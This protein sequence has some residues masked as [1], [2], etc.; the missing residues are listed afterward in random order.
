MKRGI[1]LAL[2]CAAG[3]AAQ[4]QYAGLVISEIITN[5]TDDEMIEVTNT[6]ASNIDISGVIVSDEETAR[7]EGACSFPASTTLAAGAT[8]VIAVGASTVEPT[9]LDTVPA[10]VQVFTEPGRVS[11]GWTPAHGNTITAMVDFTGATGTTGG[12][13][14]SGTDNAILLQPSATFSS[15]GIVD[16][17]LTIDG[18]SWDGDGPYCPINSTGQIDTAITEMSGDHRS[19]LS[20]QRSNSNPSIGS[21]QTYVQDSSNVGTFPESNTAKIRNA[22][23]YQRTVGEGAVAKTLRFDSLFSSRQLINF[24]DYDDAMAGSD[25]EFRY[26]TSPTRKTVPA[27][28]AE[29]PTATVGIN[30]N[31]FDINGTGETV[32]Y[33]KVNNVVVKN[34]DDP[35]HVGGVVVDASGNTRTMVRPSSG[36]WTGVTDPNVMS[37][38]FAIVA[39]RVTVSGL[40]NVDRGPRTAVGRTAEGHVLM[41]VVDGRQSMADGMSLLELARAMVALGATDAIALD[42][43]GSST[44]WDS[45]LPSN[46]VSNLPSDGGLRIVAN[47]LVAKIPASAAPV[48]AYDARRAASSFHASPHAPKNVTIGSGG[49][50]SISFSFVNYG[51]TTW[52]PSTV[53]LGTSETFDHAGAFY[54][55]ADWISPTRATALDQASVPPGGTGS[56]TFILKAPAVASSQVIE[57]SFALVDGSGNFFGPWQNRVYAVV[58]STLAAGEIV[59]ESRDA[60]GNV[61]ASPAYSE[62]GS[63][64]NTSSVS[65]ASN[66]GLSAPGGRYNT[67]IGSTATFHPTI[68]TAGNYNVYVT[69]GSGTNNNCVANFSIANAGAPVTGSANLAY[70]NGAVVNQ[71]LLLASNVPMAAGT[72][73]GITFTNTNGNAST[74]RFVMNAV[75][76]SGPLTS[77]RDDWSIY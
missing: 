68:V 64:A 15:T 48:P 10:G 51:T 62:S 56:F 65:T 50:A 57:E 28:A 40:D 35:G 12:I 3:T 60:A 20:Y 36:G 11:T 23:Y 9:W 69:L 73:G 54:N 16:G 7:N 17:T 45:D 39:N 49:T 77:V 6:S 72:S 31:F 41:V 4:A 70:T 44:M 25:M 38:N 67:T 43:G 5:P 14:L 63:F 22:V 18:V 53:Y 55:D 58:T 33:L 32:D 71:W 37:T 13:A 42:G 52:T 66:P 61:T 21:F 24:V 2:L 19:V 47:A 34:I 29:V 8:A 30:G 26:G 27:F 75:R 46:G 1:L 76:F 59:V 74:N